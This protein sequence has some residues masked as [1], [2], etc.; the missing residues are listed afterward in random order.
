MEVVTYSSTITS[1]FNLSRKRGAPPIVKSARAAIERYKFARPPGADE[2]F[3][4]KIIFRNGE[5]EGEA[6]DALEIYN[7][8]VIV[9]AS[10]DSEYLERFLTDV[11]DWFVTDTGARRIETHSINTLYESQLNVIG[12]DKIMSWLKGLDT[13]Q[14]AISR[15]LQ[16]ASGISVPYCPGGFMLTTDD[17]K[18]LGLK[19]APFRIE[20]RIGLEFERNFFISTAPLRSKDHIEILKQLEL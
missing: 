16:E 19:P 14:G 17:T 13:I 7:D 1:L 9:R 2:L 4:D 8:G 6:V 10:C 3:S 11:I 20:R 15:G 5:F 18:V 12:S